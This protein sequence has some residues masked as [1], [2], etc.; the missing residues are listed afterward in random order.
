MDIGSSRMNG[1]QLIKAE[2]RAL[3]SRGWKHLRVTTCC[4][5]T[6]VDGGGLETPVPTKITNPQASV[7]LDSPDGENYLYMDVLRGDPARVYSA[8]P[9]DPRSHDRVLERAFHQHNAIVELTTAAING[10]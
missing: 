3:V 10:Q 5:E 7:E 9:D 1:L 4:K 2:A 6:N 8:G